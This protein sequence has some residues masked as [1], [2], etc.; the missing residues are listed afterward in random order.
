M[1]KTT[2]TRVALYVPAGYGDE[3]KNLFVSVG[4]VNYLLPRGSTSMVPPAV[5][6]EVERSRRA[7]ESFQR[8]CLCLQKEGV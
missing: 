4:G 5:A 2:E 3:E 1:K 7:E 8:R 6:A